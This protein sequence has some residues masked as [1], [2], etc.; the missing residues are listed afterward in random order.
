[1][2]LIDSFLFHVGS[3]IYML[4]G[5]FV[6]HVLKLANPNKPGKKIFIFIAKV[7]DTVPVQC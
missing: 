2:N 7:R 3:D 5:R 1:M 4:V 6:E